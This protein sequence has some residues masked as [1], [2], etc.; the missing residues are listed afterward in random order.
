MGGSRTE[1]R[2]RLNAE[3]AVSCTLVRPSARHSVGHQ[4]IW[5]CAHRPPLHS[6]DWLTLTAPPLW[7]ELEVTQRPAPQGQSS[8]H[9]LSKRSRSERNATRCGAMRKERGLNHNRTRTKEDR[10][11][12][13][14]VDDFRFNS[15]VLLED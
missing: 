1:T 12:Q 7:L 10:W 14:G 2:I 11:R 4:C 5:H 9:Q 13:F 15:G 6:R 3:H 8:D